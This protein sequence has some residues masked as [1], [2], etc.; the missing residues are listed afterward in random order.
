MVRSLCGGR[1]LRRKRAIS[2]CSSG[3]QARSVTW[4]RAS[5][6]RIYLSYNP[7]SRRD[8]TGASKKATARSRLVDGSYGVFIG[9]YVSSKRVISTPEGRKAGR[10]FLLF[11]A[12]H[13]VFD[14]GRNLRAFSSDTRPSQNPLELLRGQE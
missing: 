6:C 9:F 5:P 2:L 7:V 8:H 3:V 12:E 13:R 1:R 4:P 10:Y 14:T 11:L